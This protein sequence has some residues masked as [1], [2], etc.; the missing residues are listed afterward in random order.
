MI[1][2]CTSTAC[3]NIAT[4]VI[5]TL[6]CIP[7]LFMIVSPLKLLHQIQTKESIGDFNVVLVPP[8]QAVSLTYLICTILLILLLCL[9]G[10]VAKNYFLFIP[11]FISFLV[12]TFL[13]LSVL[14]Y[15]PKK[16]QAKMITFV[17]TEFALV[18]MITMIALITFANKPK[19]SQGILG[20]MCCVALISMN[21]TPFIKIREI[22]KEKNVDGIFAP[23]AAG[24]TITG[25]IWTLYGFLTGDGVRLLFFSYYA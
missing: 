18:L 19:V 21:I 13:C 15:A 23:M 24:M 8:M 4:Y 3:Q 16:I 22:V 9:D 7:L 25:I 17:V 6:G 14:P 20:I 2:Y 10:L 11:N 1:D 5:P 12:A